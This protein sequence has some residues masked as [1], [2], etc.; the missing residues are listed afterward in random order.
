M[1]LDNELAVKQITKSMKYF[2]ENHLM[3]SFAKSAN[4]VAINYIYLGEYD[5][6]IFNLK[7]SV[8][9]FSEMCSTSYHYPLNNLATVYAH[10]GQYDKALECF[11]IA[12]D[13][14]I[15][16]FSYLWIS[17]NIANCKRKLGNLEECER[18]LNMVEDEINKLKDN[19]YLL[20]RN[21]H[22]ST[23]LLQ[24]EKRDYE[25]AYVNCKQALELEVNV[26]QNDTYHIY[27]SKLLAIL[28]EKTGNHLPKIAKTYKDSAESPFCK[29][30][31]EF[32]THWGNLLFWEV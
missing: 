24:L 30:L 22:I 9:I 12:K 25:Q 27:F 16:P 20:R 14:P 26:L 2:K 13:N 10:L 4:N 3:V 6:A 23:A 29:N 11:M 21:F 15:E 28:A 17:I 7:D 18:L 31:L 32:R 1:F 5:K 8:K 19:T